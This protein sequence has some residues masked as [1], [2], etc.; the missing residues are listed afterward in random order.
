MAWRAGQQR[1]RRRGL[2]RDPSV[3]QGN[4]DGLIHLEY[5]QF[6]ANDGMMDHA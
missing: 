5:M 6:G 4:D 2:H 3:A 1:H